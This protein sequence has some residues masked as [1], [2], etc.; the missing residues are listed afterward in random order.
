M[1]NVHTKTISND[2]T[3]STQNVQYITGGFENSIAHTAGR[4]LGIVAQYKYQTNKFQD[5]T[6]CEQFGD[7]MLLDTH[8]VDLQWHKHQIDDEKYQIHF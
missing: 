7:R 5:Q 2:Q 6:H 3:H 8:G 4:I 1:C